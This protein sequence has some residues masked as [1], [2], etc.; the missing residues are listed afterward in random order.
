LTA[1]VLDLATHLTE[2]SDLGYNKIT[3]LPLYVARARLAPFAVAKM[4][5]IDW[6]TG[7]DTWRQHTDRFA[8]NSPGYPSPLAHQ[9]DGSVSES[10]ILQKPSAKLTYRR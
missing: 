5:K 3:R 4:T 7:A 1:A 2:V 6:S 10:V 8:F 9:F